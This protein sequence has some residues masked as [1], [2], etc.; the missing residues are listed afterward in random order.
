MILPDLVLAHAEKGP[1]DSNREPG[2]PAPVF[3]ALCSPTP[4]LHSC[5]DR[6]RWRAQPLTRCG[7]IRIEKAVDGAVVRLD[8]KLL[9]KLVCK[10]TAEQSRLFQKSSKIF[11]IPVAAPH[12]KL[13]STIRPSRASFLTQLC[14]KRDEGEFRARLRRLHVRHVTAALLILHLNWAD[15]LFSTAR[16]HVK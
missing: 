7:G 3:P 11:L 16:H 8:S 15:R 2:A 10:F 14:L 4:A 1:G 5:L 13:A 9:I 6:F 12:R